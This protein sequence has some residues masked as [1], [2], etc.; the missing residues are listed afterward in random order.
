MH[1]R[2]DG[3]PTILLTGATGYV[4][5]R[6]LSR[7]LESGYT[8]RCA[9]RSPESLSHISQNSAE[10]VRA[11]LF[12]YDSLESALNGIDVAFYLVHSLGSASDFEAKERLCGENFARAAKSAGVGRVI[13]LGG[14]GSGNEL[15]P[16][17]QTRQA[18]GKILR[19]S[20]V[21]TIEFRASIII[22]SGSLSFEMVRA[23]VDRLP[24]MITPRWVRAKAQPIA[25]EDVL[26]Y[27][28][29][30]ISL[31]FNGSQ[32][33]EIGGPDVVSYMGIM[34]EYAR[35]RG[36]TRIMI[37]V[38]FLTPR[39]SSLWLGLVTPLYARVGKKLVDS[40][41]HDTLVEDQSALTKFA[42]KPRGFSAAISRALAN[43][44]REFAQTRWSDAFSA[45]GELQSWGG[46]R[47]GSRLVD[48]RTFKANCAS[49]QAFS[50]IRAIGGSNG[51]YYANW[52]WSLRGL[53]D[54]LVGGVGVRRGRASQ[55]NLRVG[56]VLDFWRVE[57]FEPNKLLRLRAE[58]KLPG[59][60][61]LQFEV[62][63]DGEGSTIRQTAL[64]DPLGVFG[65]LYW[66]CLY[67]V[68]VLIFAG[69]LR[70]IGKRT[71]ELGKHST[72]GGA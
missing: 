63:E 26:D 42:I 24:V 39:L 21:Q 33:F 56:D 31:E 61:W 53:I 2:L 14:L 65:L 64:F 43:E 40:I 32:V 72:K 13:Y 37:P 29:A 23:L 46:T 9:A 5:G 38:P 48:S 4:G 11:D 55:D 41:Q 70:E 57:A 27:L 58:M 50:P 1:E 30:A 25:I 16:H 66:Y 3:K 49:S 34:C 6:L 54:L 47:F 62:T 19:D 8:V 20:G 18:V 44:D 15:S 59:R 71:T 28:C 36:V 51:W 35:Q 17:L 22:G 7:L 10:V 67:P 60:A 69:M 52:A 68:H 12:D 45:A